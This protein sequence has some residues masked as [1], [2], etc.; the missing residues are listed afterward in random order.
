LLDHGLP[1]SLDGRTI[2]GEQA[3]AGGSVEQ[4]ALDSH[5]RL[6]SQLFE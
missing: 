2:T 4:D 6:L 1:Y 5:H 3:G